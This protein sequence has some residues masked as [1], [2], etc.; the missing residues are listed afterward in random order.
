MIL[1]DGQSFLNLSE[2]NPRIN[3]HL[4]RIDI[5]NLLVNLTNP[6]QFH[7]YHN[8][9]T[10]IT[11]LVFNITQLLIDNGYSGIVEG[12]NYTG[13]N[14][15][16]TTGNLTFWASINEHYGGV[17]PPTPYPIVSN[18]LIDN[19][20]I[21]EAMLSH[22]NSQVVD[23]SG[24]QVIIVAPKPTK[25]IIKINGTDPVAP[26]VVKPGDTVTFSLL[27]DVPTSNLHS[28]NLIDY[29]PIPLLKATQF[30]TGQEQNTSQFIPAAGQWRIGE[31][32][33]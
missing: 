10:G 29:L 6:N 32:I 21:A 24:T 3:L 16:P 26:Y 9:T 33:P 30:T 8:S 7:Y 31:M 11:Y 12:G 25:D 4:P 17:T 27:I 23:N 15:G 22:N 1:G 20:V 13:T 5:N 2:Y 28:F 14:F 19:K 18:D